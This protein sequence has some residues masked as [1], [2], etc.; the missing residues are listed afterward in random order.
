MKFR[1]ETRKS[2]RTPE[3]QARIK[4][5]RERFQ[6][7]RP[8]HEELIASAEYDGPFP[9]DLVLSFLIA[10]AKLRAERERQGLTL[11]EVAQRAGLDAELLSRLESGE[12][13]NPNLATLSRF[14]HALGLTFQVHVCEPVSA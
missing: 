8:T 6:R 13:M 2:D 1:G 9:Q 4:A 14:A 5:I 10:V 7:E 11:A 3:E 12:A